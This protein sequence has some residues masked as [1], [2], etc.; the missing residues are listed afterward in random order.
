[1]R[2]PIGF[3]ALFLADPPRRTTTCGHCGDS[4]TGDLADGRAWL[5]EHSAS[6]H[7]RPAYR[8]E[9]RAGRAFPVLQ[10]IPATMFSTTTSQT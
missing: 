9:P 10:P 2:H 4:F 6:E 5:T 7:V 3:F 1:M 8:P